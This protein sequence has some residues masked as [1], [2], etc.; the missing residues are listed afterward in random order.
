MRPVDPIELL[1]TVRALLRARGI[2]DELKKNKEIAEQA[3]AAAELANRLKDD[4]LAT[5]SHELRTPLNAIIGW[6]TLLRAP[7]TT[8]EDL[9]EGLETIERN[10]KVQAQ[11][12]EDLLD[13]SRIISGKLRLDTQP[14]DLMPIIHAAITSV[15][16]AA[17]AKGIRLTSCPT[18]GAETGAIAVMG[19]AARLQ[20]VV[21]NLLTNAIKFTPRGGKVSIALN[22]DDEHAIL[23]VTDTGKG[24]AAS[25]LPHAFDRFRQADA[26]WLRPN[27]RRARSCRRQRRS[28]PRDR[29]DGV[30]PPGRS[31]PR[32]DGGF[33]V[34][35][36]QARK[37]RRI[38]RRHRSPDRPHWHQKLAGML[39]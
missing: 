24:I 29:A 27:R 6:A 25:F 1:A 18:D 32:V 19:D 30:R 20:Q 38:D 31:N 11:L 17:E 14:I 3:Q 5:L 35:R 26:R 2:E 12:I 39:T 21:W 13:I 9:A 7:S 8:A 22:R 4:F 16:P 33:S 34:A 10:A 15:T 28:H 36:R 37:S 23:T